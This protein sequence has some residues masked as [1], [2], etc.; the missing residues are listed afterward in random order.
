MGEL[1]GLTLSACIKD[2]FKSWNPLS[3]Y[4]TTTSSLSR[5]D[6][7]L[8]NH[9]LF[10]LQ[11]DC[12]HCHCHYYYCLQLWRGRNRSH[13]SARTLQSRAI[14]S[15]TMKPWW[16]NKM[17]HGLWKFSLPRSW[18]TTSSSDCCWLHSSFCYSWTTALKEFS[19]RVDWFT[20]SGRCR[21]A[22]VCVIALGRR[23]IVWCSGRTESGRTWR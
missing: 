9:D 19:G 8:A 13:F 2:T 14:V 20:S 12:Y 4:T 10:A 16:H 3:R 1:G 15:F 6:L 23:R 17:L 22:I 21:R 7:K 5:S 18:S 11:E